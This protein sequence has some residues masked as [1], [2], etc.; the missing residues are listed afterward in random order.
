LLL[1]ELFMAPGARRAP[2]VTLSPS[3][4]TRLRIGKRN[5]VVH[6]FGEGPLCL[7][8]HGWQGGASQLANLAESVSAAGFRVALFDMPAHGEAPG[9]STSAVE[10]VDIIHGVARAL[11]PVH[12]LIG[13]SL[14][15]TASL[16]AA[17]RGL[18]VAGVV[19]FSPP[20]SF[21]FAVRN[22]ARA[23]GLTPRV[24]E[25]LARRLER[26][27]GALREQLDLT[28]SPP[29]VPT[30]LVH[31][32]MDRVI[33][34]RHSRRLRDGWSGAQLLQTCG[35]GHNRVLDGEDVAQNIAAFLLELAEGALAPRQPTSSER[36][37]K[38]DAERAPLDEVRRIKRAR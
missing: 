3:T 5:I 6:A 12:A 4:R 11:G 16:V 36:R 29:G 19:A 30:L 18:P 37:P 13:H 25:I 23:F 9:V 17:S 24:R 33:P 27:T 32:L 10:F 14:G 35:L 31:D 26:R 28:R 8:V 15:G 7:L 21:E 20:P 22:Y 38:P 34:Y 2:L 1:A